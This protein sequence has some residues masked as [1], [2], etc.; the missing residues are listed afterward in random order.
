MYFFLNSHRSGNDLSFIFSS[1]QVLFG[2]ES[3]ISLNALKE[4]R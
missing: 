3:K 1:E 4:V 2:E